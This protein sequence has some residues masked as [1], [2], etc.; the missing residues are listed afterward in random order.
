MI[1]RNELTIL[2]DSWLE[3]HKIK[4][5]TFNGLQFEGKRSITHIACA[6]DVSL[7]TLTQAAKLGVDFLITHHGLIWGGL[8]KI[9]S[10]DKNRI[11]ILCENN[12]NLYCSH[13]P[14]DIH[15]KLGNNALL[16]KL[17]N[18]KNTEEIFFDVG[19]YANIDTSYHQLKETIREYISEKIVEMNF[20]P[21]KINKIAICSGGATLDLKALFEASSKGVQTILSGETN[22]LY[23]HYA[24]ELKMNI[25]CAGHYATETFG[26]RA[27][28]REIQKKYK[29][30]KSIIYTFIDIPTGF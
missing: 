2:L 7:D 22:S 15:K 25:L 6:V 27:V 13:L 17:L 3:P 30:Q 1:D 20:G 11:Q 4:D 18:A 26:I 5:Y 9:T 28:S 16:I 24:K 23:Y 14:L 12:M 21:D 29:D 19:Y 8:Q 10:F